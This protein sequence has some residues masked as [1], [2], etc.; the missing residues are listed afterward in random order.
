MISNSHIT[1]LGKEQGVYVD[2]NK[3]FISIR[4]PPV[5][6]K[7]KFEMFYDVVPK[8]SERNFNVILLSMLTGISL[9]A[10]LIS[11]GIIQNIDVIVIKQI[12][13]HANTIFGGI[14]TISMAI[15]G[16]FRAPIYN[17]LRYWFTIPMIISSIG[18]LF[19]INS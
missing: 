8:K 3:R 7:T 6:E 18:F 5:E 10:T 15:I 12:F 19:S 9:I 13:A 4:I 16:I 14:I 11:T 2:N 17:R 1:S